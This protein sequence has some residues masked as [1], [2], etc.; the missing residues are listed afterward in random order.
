MA[1]DEYNACWIYNAEQMCTQYMKTNSLKCQLFS[2]MC[3][4]IITWTNMQSNNMQNSNQA[5][6]SFNNQQ[7]QGNN[8]FGTSFPDS[9]GM[10]R[11][12]SM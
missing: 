8:N 12:K 4:Q 1:I 3:V 9:N 6:G 2:A 7:N 11:Y 5:N 10:Q